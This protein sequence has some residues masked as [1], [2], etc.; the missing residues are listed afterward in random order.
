[1]DTTDIRRN[2]T[3]ASAAVTGTARCVAML[4]GEEYVDHATG[5]TW[6]GCGQIVEHLEPLP[7]TAKR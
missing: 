2:T 4:R 6:K 7:P 3:D 1:V 5:T